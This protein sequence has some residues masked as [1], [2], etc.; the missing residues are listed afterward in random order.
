[1]SI[2]NY[3]FYWLKKSDLSFEN[4]YQVLRSECSKKFEI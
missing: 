1:M 4:M 3:K 2:G